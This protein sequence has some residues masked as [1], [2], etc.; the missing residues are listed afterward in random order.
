MDGNQIDEV[1]Y[2][3]VK[4]NGTPFIDSAGILR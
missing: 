3:H 1:I 4:F 2:V